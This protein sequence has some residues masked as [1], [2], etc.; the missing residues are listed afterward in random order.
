MKPYINF[1]LLLLA[2]STI[3][4]Q[5][6]NFGEFVVAENTVFSNE[7]AFTN[8]SNASFINDGE[9][10]FYG[11]LL[12]NGIV[13]YTS[14]SIGGTHF[15]GNAL[16]VISGLAVS[17]FNNIV[18]NNT[19]Q[20]L[21]NISVNS[22]VQIANSADFIDGIVNVDADSG[23]FIF[24]SNAIATNANNA[25][26][27]DGIV[28]KQG[29]N[30]F[31][32]P[33][34][35]SS[36]HREVLISGLAD[37]DA[38]FT[39]KYHFE[40]PTITYPKERKRGVIEVVNDSEYWVVENTSGNEEVLITLSW[41]ENATPEAI[42]KGPKTGIHVIR[43]NPVEELWEHEGGVVDEAN[44]QVTTLST[45]ENYGI[46]TLGRVKENSILPTGT[47]VYN[48]ISVNND[49]KN[50]FFNIIDIE[51]YPNNTVEIF[52][53]WGAKLYS[54]NNYASNGNVFRGFR[55]IGDGIGNRALPTGT[56]YY[57]ILYDYTLDGTTRRAKK[58]GFLYI[59]SD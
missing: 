44:R 16:Q 15:V 58:A 48:A 7:E 10:Y 31:N 9:T 32:F 35:D 22:T 55:E 36:Y 50:D 12:N 4:A 11:D 23:Q 53:R 28:N 41:Q 46:F 1:V 8:D 18:F 27:V 2:S 38:A 3:T 40:D 34:G 47:A 42:L 5:T 29:N 56:Y 26:F 21:A 59:N 52:N 19:D 25:S 57:V 51:D 39:A 45:V 20:E 49:G 13:D 43:W 24:E 33:V 6:H 37:P 54:T 14:G 30:D 17:Y